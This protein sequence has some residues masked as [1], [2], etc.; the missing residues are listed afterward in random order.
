MIQS[1]KF[2]IRLYRKFKSQATEKFEHNYMLLAQQASRLIKY[3][4]YV[5]YFLLTAS[6]WQLWYAF[7]HGSYTV[8]GFFKALGIELASGLFNRSIRNA[9]SMQAKRWHIWSM[10]WVIVVISTAANL[11]F[12][13]ERHLAE[14]TAANKIEGG[15][16]LNWKNIIAYCD[17]LN[18]IEAFFFS[19]FIQF[20]AIGV[21]KA[22]AT[23]F[24]MV[25]L[26]VEREEERIERRLYFK[27]YRR[28]KRGRGKAKRGRGRGKG[29]RGG[30]R[31]GVVR[32]SRK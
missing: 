10:L 18:H 25:E 4:D 29:K 1:I 30:A 32:K 20:I 13:Y 2:V 16:V 15:I 28:A 3:Y 7:G 31:R 21:I 6:G 5:V 26:Y 19:G 14:Y 22:A 17:I 27:K 8:A 11:R 9:E 23:Q 12:E 24:S